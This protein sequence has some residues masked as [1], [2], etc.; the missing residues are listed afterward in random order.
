MGGTLEDAADIL[1][2]TVAR[3]HYAKWSCGSQAR[4]SELL[5]RIWDAKESPAQVEENEP[6]HAI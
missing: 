1:D 6:F 3:T 4:I 5:A 2:D